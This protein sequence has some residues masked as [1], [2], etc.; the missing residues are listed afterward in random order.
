MHTKDCGLSQQGLQRARICG[1]S[2]P[3]TGAVR[4]PEH[5]ERL[6]KLQHVFVVKQSSGILTPAPL[7]QRRGRAVVSYLGSDEAHVLDVF[8]HTRV[9]GYVFVGVK[10]VKLTL[11]LRVAGGVEH[12][13]RFLQSCPRMKESP[14]EKL[15]ATIPRQGHCKKMKNRK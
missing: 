4:R 2:D 8:N 5:L 14:R 3:D 1:A 9:R 11:E 7:C 12:A 15:H 10:V 6:G 13:D